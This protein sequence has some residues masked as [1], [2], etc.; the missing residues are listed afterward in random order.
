MRSLFKNEK[1]NANITSK[2]IYNST[3]ISINRQIHIC[4]HILY[5]KHLLLDAVTCNYIF[6]TLSSQAFSVKND[7]SDVLDEFFYNV[8]KRRKYL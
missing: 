1:Q 7:Y 3:Y 5:H 2:K 4:R 8:K 6:N